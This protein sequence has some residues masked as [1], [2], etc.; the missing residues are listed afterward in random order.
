MLAEEIGSIMGVFIWGGLAFLG[1]VR[2]ALVAKNGG[3]KV[4]YI[5][6]SLL[7]FS[8]VLMAILNKSQVKD[9]DSHLFVLLAVPIILAVVVGMVLVV[10]GAVLGRGRKYPVRARGWLGAGVV[11]GWIVIG[12]VI[13]GM[14]GRF[15]E[16][17]NV[18]DSKI[19]EIAGKKVSGKGFRLKQPQKS[20]ISIKPDLVN[21]DASY[22]YRRLR[23]EVYC[24]IINE[25]ISA[26]QIDLSLAEGIVDSN[27]QAA[28]QKCEI[29]H[30]EEIGF[31][32]HKAIER[33][34]KVA[35]AGSNY[36][37]YQFVL[38]S[39]ESLF[40]MHLWKL[41][42][43][44]I[45]TDRKVLER[46][47]REFTEGLVFTGNPAN[48][49]IVQDIPTKVKEIG[50]EI[51]G[52]LNEWID[53]PNATEEMPGASWS[54]C[55][56]KMQ[57]VGVYGV[58]HDEREEDWGIIEDALLKRLNM[59]AT[60]DFLRPV[61][62]TTEEKR[63]DFI[64]KQIG[65]GQEGCIRI[66]H[67]AGQGS[68]LIAG[69]VNKDQL[70]GLPAVRSLCDS[71]VIEKPDGS[72]IS[73]IG[74]WNQALMLN[75]IG[76][77]YYEKGRMKESEIFFRKAHGLYPSD[78]T[79]CS[80][81]CDALEALGQWRESLVFLEGGREH[82]D[83]DDAWTGR[84]AVAAD[85]AQEVEKARL[86][87]EKTFEKGYH[88][89]TI[90]YSYMSFLYTHSMTDG[91]LEKIKGYNDS[92]STRDSMRTYIQVCQAEGAYDTAFDLI[93]E[94][95][96]KHPADEEI[97]RMEMDVCINAGL[98]DKGLIK[99]D[100]LSKSGATGVDFQIMQGKLLY[101]A[102][103]Y[104]ESRGVFEDVLR[105]YSQN[106]SA[107]EYVAALNAVQE[108]GSR[109]GLI[110]GV[111]P[112]AL[113]PSISLNMKEAE[114][115]EIKEVGRQELYDVVAVEW[116]NREKVQKTIY[117]KSVFNDQRS[118]NEYTVYEYSFDESQYELCP[119]SFIV[120]NKA[121]E[122]VNKNAIDSAYV[123][124][125]REQSILRI[126]VNGLE[127]GGSLEVII[128]EQTVGVEEEPPFERVYMFNF[129]E[130]GYM[131]LSIRGLAEKNVA[132]YGEMTYRQEGLVHIWERRKIP[133]LYYEARQPTGA[134]VYP[135]IALGSGQSTWS[136]IGSEYLDSISH[137]LKIDPTVPS[138]WE[139]WGIK[140]QAKE[141]D[142]VGDVAEQVQQ[143]LSYQNIAFGK[144]RRVPMPCGQIIRNRTGDCK[145]HSLL[146]W[147]LLT[148]KE[149]EAYLVLVNSSEQIV[150]T[151]PNLDQFDHMIVAT[152][153]DKE[154]FV[155]W[156]TTNKYSAMGFNNHSYL[157]EN[158]ALLLNGNKSRLIQ[159]STKTGGHK[160]TVN[161]VVKIT[162][163]GDVV[164]EDALCFDGV[165]AESWRRALVG[166][167]R[168]ASNR[169]VEQVYQS[170]LSG[171]RLSEANFD[172]L[173]PARGALIGD[174]KGLM[175]R[176]FRKFRNEWIG[177]VALPIPEGV[178]AIEQAG[179]RKYAIHHK[180]TEEVIMHYRIQIPEGFKMSSVDAVEDIDIQSAYFTAEIS[181]KRT[182]KEIKLEG[183]VVIHEG[184]FSAA[185]WGA[186][187]E[188]MDSIVEALRPTVALVRSE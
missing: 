124:A 25:N 2:C 86:L 166:V 36:L 56:L 87:Y 179:P 39:E 158:S 58:L 125:E 104:D 41:H 186:Y 169:V 157:Y 48:N 97:D 66:T 113:M 111:L 35:Y 20:W 43:G 54:V 77:I 117:R 50:V 27:L 155:F 165:F 95:M 22:V 121:G 59:R 84:M 85:M 76:L 14:Y 89:D 44:V 174:V 81:V 134:S 6:G 94:W 115:V 69:W 118:I 109:L 177:T 42:A 138:L 1:G 137:R 5:G 135:F 170:K 136:K 8:Y 82:F 15:H 3:N 140:D 163:T 67:V 127:I 133:A 112:V 80:N 160:L 55:S 11:L 37:Y 143:Y 110:T 47:A 188:E 145:A 13:Y 150:E 130:V 146:L 75:D 184:I 49:K 141:E 154:G 32:G 61:S 156:D 167:D 149:I 152:G 12:G 151:L 139:E 159:K 99:A 123:V 168:E 62:A 91:I 33:I 116:K 19:A 153:N 178:V 78:K 73:E 16:I 119:H 161:S 90:Y 46:S 144:Q 162:E 176:A 28:G 114:R 103:R 120:R 60:T 128:T 132:N 142:V 187:A 70:S 107:L 106:E 183:R 147:Q 129:L 52:E 18:S 29:I 88:D 180:Q 182:S 21:P 108:K 96:K 122:I 17:S 53:F 74:L 26:L 148:S 100:K 68:Y 51:Q 10:V 24:M 83:I 102:E 72:D 171:F 93:D 131:A 38:V 173:V 172:S 101:G 31:Q 175:K 40:Q 9:D 126:P 4:L 63:W 98:Y 45:D 185:E 64:D 57:T 181:Q 65:V 105:V 34:V 164:Y 23:P 30:R 79:I 7:L 92:A 71:V